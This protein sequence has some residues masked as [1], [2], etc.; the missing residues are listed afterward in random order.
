[1][2][3]HSRD[4]VQYDFPQMKELLLRDGPNKWNYITEESIEYQFQLIREDKAFAIIAEESEIIGFAV[5]LSH[6]SCPS[7]L[8]KY[9]QSEHI[10]YIKDVIVSKN[11]NGKGIGS[12]LLQECLSVATMK[13]G[14]EVYIERHE[15]NLA[16]AAM[17]RKVGFDIVE[18]FYDPEKR[19]KGSRNTT[20]MVI[21]LS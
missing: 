20:I 13:G 14:H 19:D 10:F 21:K 1:M 16:S 12:K 18:T 2:K 8:D 7:K 9:T 11:H 5:L 4:L 6:A 3:I 17:M 15:E